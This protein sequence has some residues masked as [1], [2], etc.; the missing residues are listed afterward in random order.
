MAWGERSTKEK[1]A[2]S[3]ILED[4]KL[5]QSRHFHT[6]PIKIMFCPTWYQ[7]CRTSGLPFRSINNARINNHF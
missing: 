3:C 5:C 4:H 2:T 6:L 1:E 7:I